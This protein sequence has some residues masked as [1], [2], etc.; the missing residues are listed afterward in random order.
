MW[1]IDLI[2]SW[3]GP[4]VEAVS[5]YRDKDEMPADIGWE[6]FTITT[7]YFICP[8]SMLVLCILLSLEK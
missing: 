6:I 5:I 4:G 1:H 8:L 2:N 3:R 7:D